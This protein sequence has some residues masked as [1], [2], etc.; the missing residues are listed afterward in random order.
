MC[1]YIDLVS[2]TYLRSVI[3][4]FFYQLIPM[5]E[6]SLSRVHAELSIIV[7]QYSTVLILL[8][9]DKNVFRNMWKEKNA[10]YELSIYN[11]HGHVSVDSRWKY[12]WSRSLNHDSI[13]TKCM[14]I[15]ESY[16]ITIV[17]VMRYVVSVSSKCS[18]C[19]HL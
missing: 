17:F 1:N 19:T 8:S 16:L 14:Q 18:E 5:R 12:E 9:I 11:F 13:W 3:I 10:V 4:Y 2:L 7:I 15:N 6:H